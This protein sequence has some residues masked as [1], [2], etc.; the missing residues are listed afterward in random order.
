[1][2]TWQ[3]I[4]MRAAIPTVLCWIM[5]LS[6]SPAARGA[7]TVEQRKE[8]A[9]LRKQLLKEVSPLLKKKK[10]AEAETSLKSIEDK[11]NE[12][13]IPVTE[14]DRTYRNL[15]SSLSQLK[16][17]LP[18][19]F[20]S[21]VAPILKSNCIRCHADNP[22][23]NLR[24]DTFSG[25]RRGG[26]NGPLA[27]AGNPNRSMIIARLITPQRQL[28]MPKNGSALKRE[29]IETIATWIRQGA[30]F[31]GT[32]MDAPIGSSA[33]D[34]GAAPKPKEKIPVV[35]A[36]GSETVSFKKDIAPWMVNL[37]VRCHSGNNPRSGYSLDTFEK[38]LQSGDTGE[39]IVTGGNLEESYLWDL[40]G[41][42]KPVKMPMGQA[43]ITRTNHA[44]L[45]KWIEEGAK[46]DGTDP[47]LPLRR[48]IPSA[49]DMKREELA[50]LSPEEWEKKRGEQADSMWKRVAPK[51]EPNKE[52]TAN[53]IVYGNAAPARLKQLGEW[54]EA[55]VEKLQSL[56][57]TKQSPLWKG[58][59]IVF[60]TKDRF[61]YEE[62]NQVLLQRQTPDSM[63]GHS[64]ATADED[65]AYVVVQDV[66]DVSTSQSASL[67]INLID[68]LTG[69]F[70]KRAGDTV[71]D[72]LLR[73]TGLAMAA[74]DN[75]KDEYLRSLPVVAK[76]TLTA[77]G[78]PNEVFRNGTFS[79]SETG[80]VGFLLVGY[81][82]QKGGAPRFGRLLQ[83]LQTGKNPAEALQTVYGSKPGEIAARLFSEL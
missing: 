80:P 55:H 61:A 13:K 26:Q 36:D 75:P 77:L 23:G 15:V 41:K 73:G 71:P 43:R 46:F 27:I 2:K 69:A 16:A 20:E 48:I 64:V 53:F 6:F 74:K 24:L 54:G 17:R 22:R 25:L 83:Q 21:K 35:M 81:L 60:V 58:R 39:R 34:G 19:S 7:I 67:N 18:V 44:N 50:K 79:P 33:V 57:K 4:F 8:L 59:L 68:H 12:M 14:K 40:V 10:F 82:L 32:S 51:E 45:R 37:C 66:G 28:R 29:D 56:F 72:W 76:R 65:Q 62:F 38:L 30:R 47:K 31:D 42:Q 11:F 1:M 9:A 49:A 3:S 78:N 70:L 63:T 52:T 5:M